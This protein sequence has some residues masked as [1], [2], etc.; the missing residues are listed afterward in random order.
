MDDWSFEGSPEPDLPL[1]LTHVTKINA[2]RWTFRHED[3]PFPDL[4]DET[5]DA[6]G[7]RGAMVALRV[8]VCWLR[9]ICTA[10]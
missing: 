8:R 7:V 4:G 1:Q 5:V 3:L 2:Q 10:I 6:F 9:E